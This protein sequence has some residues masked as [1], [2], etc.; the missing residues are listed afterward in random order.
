MIRVLLYLLLILL[1]G[2]T[3]QEKKSPGVFFAGEI[4]NPTGDKIVLYKGDKVVD[5]SSLDK[6]NR[7]SFQFD[8]I[9]EGLYHF[10]HAPELQYVYL[11]QGDSLV[12]R[13]NTMDF[14]ES[15]IFSGTGSEIN[16]FLLELFLANE[17]EDSKISAWY[18]LEASEFLGKIDELQKEKFETLGEL[19]KDGNLSQNQRNL[20]K[21]SIV[22]N[23]NT[24]KEQYPFRHRRYSDHGV[25]EKLPDNFYQYRKSVDYGNEQLTYLRPYYEFMVNHIQ[26]LSFMSCTKECQ[27]KEGVVQKQ[28]HFNEHKLH[29][30]DSLVSEKELKDN[31]YR[32]VAFNY[33][34]KVHDYPENN[35]RFITKFHE[36]SNNNR[37]LDEIDELYEGIEN[38]QPQKSI[39]DVYV[40]NFAGDS[41]SLREIGKE[42]KTVFYFWSAVDKKH[43]NSIKKRVAELTVKNPEYKYVGINMKTSKDTWKGMVEDSRLNKDQQYRAHDFSKLTKS[44][45]IY[46]ENKCVITN[47]A[48]IVDAF[49]NI[50]SAFR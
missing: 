42:G 34:L 28:L 32:H 48:V 10:D 41:L 43:F 23:Y 21:A 45:I 37:H 4:V 33:L 17:E 38:L 29:L 40:T 6:N 31:L 36:L 49:S 22:Y 9:A 26:N 5:S 30:I 15:L 14:D 47:D 39:P 25:L 12:I 27:M 20:A 24:Y 46:P 11:A 1:F 13:L 16:N 19:I 8:S 3:S 2:C 35:K 7:F 50:Y 44:L 18:E